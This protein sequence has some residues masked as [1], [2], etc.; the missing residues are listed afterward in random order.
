MTKKEQPIP[1]A[2]TLAMFLRSLLAGAVIGLPLFLLSAP[3]WVFY[4]APIAM[5][6]WIVWELLRLDRKE[7][8]EQKTNTAEASRPR[9]TPRSVA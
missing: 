8:E 5:S 2:F 3:L 7:R 4:V 1:P 6:P 9:E